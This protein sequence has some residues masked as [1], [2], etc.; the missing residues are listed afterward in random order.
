MPSRSCSAWLAA[1]P[2]LLC[3]RPGPR[4]CVRA[5]RPPH[6]AYSVPCDRSIRAGVPRRL[7]APTLPFPP[8]V[9]P[10]WMA[11][12][13]P[14]GLGGA[15]LR[16]RAAVCTGARV[17]DE[18]TPERARDRESGG[19]DAKADRPTADLGEARLKRRQERRRRCDPTRRSQR[20]CS[21]CIEASRVL[22]ECNC[23]LV[24]A[25]HGA[26]T[27]ASSVSRPWRR[28]RPGLMLTPRPNW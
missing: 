21:S 5:P 3:S 9:P 18:S 1:Q 20:A 7:T 10:R 28:S 11:S 4:R 14:S 16:D 25:E 2:Q 8:T 19:D 24:N 27:C 23:V 6:R 17:A 13:A 12:C 15:I 22:D 26:H